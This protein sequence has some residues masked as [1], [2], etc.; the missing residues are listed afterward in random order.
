MTGEPFQIFGRANALLEHCTDS[1]RAVFPG[2]CRVFA[3]K[4][5]GGGL[6]CSEEIPNQIDDFVVVVGVF[7]VWERNFPLHYMRELVVSYS[8]IFMPS[9][10]G[11]MDT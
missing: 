4:G 1:R 10:P 3:K 9:T 5:V 7:K 2:T 11:H 8:K 6:G